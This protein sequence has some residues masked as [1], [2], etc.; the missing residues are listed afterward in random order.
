MYRCAK[1][2]AVS[3][4]HQRQH[5]GHRPAKDAFARLAAAAAAYTAAHRGRADVEDRRFDARFV[6]RLGHLGQCCVGAAVF[7]RAAVDQ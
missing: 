4:F 3:L 1:H 5:V 6:Q 2:D 7:V